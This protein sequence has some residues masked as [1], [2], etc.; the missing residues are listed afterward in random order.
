MQEF[1]CTTCNTLAKKVD[2]D[3]V[4]F[5]NKLNKIKKEK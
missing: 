5:E 2:D 3:V 1:V 4:S